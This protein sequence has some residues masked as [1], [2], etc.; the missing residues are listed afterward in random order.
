[1]INRL[2]VRICKRKLKRIRS[3]LRNK[4]RGLRNSNKRR[5]ISFKRMSKP[6]N[7]IKINSTRSSS[8]TSLF[9][10]KIL[11]CIRMSRR[12]PWP[13]PVTLSKSMSWRSV[14]LIWSHRS[15]SSIRI[16]ARW[17][18]QLL[19][20][21]RLLSFLRNKRRGLRNSNKRRKISFKR[22]SKPSNTIKINSTRSSSRTSLFKMKT[23]NYR[24]TLIISASNS[25]TQASRSTNWGM[26]WRSSMK[27]QKRRE[28]H[29]SISLMN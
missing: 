21:L 12:R 26:R 3:G 28:A 20:I 4:R 18:N 5:K 9:K 23:L 27:S 25:N 6:S 19:G 10:M 2:L 16:V 8:R 22:M 15:I 17:I 14:T 7:T 13:I 24:R 11:N 1:M 29:L